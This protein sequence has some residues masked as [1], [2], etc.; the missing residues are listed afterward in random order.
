MK[1]IDNTEAPMK[2]LIVIKVSVRHEVYNIHE[3]NEQ[4]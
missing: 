1:F 2:L 3:G 4:T